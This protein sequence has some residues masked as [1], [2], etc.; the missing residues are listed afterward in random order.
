MKKS[1]FIFSNV[2]ALLLCSCGSSGFTVTWL[3]YNGDVLE[4]DTGVK[5]NETPTYDQE[6]PLRAIDGNTVYRF[7]GWD[8]EVV[9]VVSDTTYTATYNSYDNTNNRLSA[10]PTLNN[11]QNTIEYGLYPQS[12]VTDESLTSI[13]KNLSKK[14]IKENG[15]YL[16]EDNYYAMAIGSSYD[17][18]QYPFDNGGHVTSSKTYFFKCE[19]IKWK[20]LSSENNNYFCLAEKVLENHTFNVSRARREINGETIYANNYEHSDIRKWLNNEFLDSAFTFG[21][22]Y[23]QDTLVDNSLES[24]TH[25]EN[26]YLCNDTIDKI[27]LPSFKDMQ[28]YDFNDD[29]SRRGLTSEYARTV[30]VRCAT[31]EHGEYITSGFYFTRTPLKTQEDEIINIPPQGTLNSSRKVDYASYGVRPCATIK[32]Y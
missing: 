1:L 29:L 4:V 16:Y 8:K 3:D 15:W 30:G 13:L 23:L 6:T 18:H 22:H 10:L 21:S 20:I 17:G 11:E 14:Y 12:L 7:K 25:N 9:P 28:S 24:T 2:L 27:F 32:I 5:K 31:D 26:P 19:P